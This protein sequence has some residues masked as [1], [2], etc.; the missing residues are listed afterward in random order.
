M[1]I[2]ENGRVILN[3]KEERPSIPRGPRTPEPNA[4]GTSTEQMRQR[5]DLE[6][7]EQE[8]LRPAIVEDATDSEWA[9]IEQDIDQNRR[10]QAQLVIAEERA[11]QSLAEAVAKA[12]PG[13]VKNSVRFAQ[14]ELADPAGGPRK[15]LHALT[16]MSRARALCR[17]SAARPAL[18]S[19]VK[20]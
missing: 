4:F 6:Q 15:A 13:Q 7:L 18:E 12:K 9:Y 14:E 10:L 11:A 3:L 1:T 16:A 19:A 8:P 2:I 5:R 17:D 20:D